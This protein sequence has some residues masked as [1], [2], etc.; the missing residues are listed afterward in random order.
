[1]Y[2]EGW[3]YLAIMG[4]LLGCGQRKRVYVIKNKKIML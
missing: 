2:I 1:M 4:N 3:Q